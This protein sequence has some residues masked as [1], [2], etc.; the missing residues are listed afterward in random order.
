MSPSLFYGQEGRCPPDC[1]GEEGK[2]KVSLR[3]N[4]HREIS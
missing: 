2:I 3:C 4:R 1:Q